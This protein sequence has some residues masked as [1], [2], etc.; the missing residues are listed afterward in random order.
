[1][2]DRPEL[3]PGFNATSYAR[4]ATGHAEEALTLALH[5]EKAMTDYYLA[6]AEKYLRQALDHVTEARAARDT[7]ERGRTA[8]AL[9]RQMNA[10]L[11]A[12]QHAM[13]KIK[14]MI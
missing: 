1:M 11:P 4:T 3:S 8:A 6:D 7:D 9:A 13:L 2:T 10:D 14:G 12:D 5:G